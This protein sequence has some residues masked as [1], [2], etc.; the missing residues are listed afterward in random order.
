[1]RSN[2]CHRGPPFKLLYYD[3]I[4]GHGGMYLY[5]LA[6]IR[7][8]LRRGMDVTWVTCD[9]T[10]RHHELDLWTPFTGIYG[11]APAWR[12][13]IRYALGLCRLLAR[14]RRESKT[15]RVIV[16]QQFA[17]VPALELAF[18]AAAR[19]LGARCVLAPHDI[20]PFEGGE[21]TAWLLPKL[22][23]QYAAL[24]SHSAAGQAELKRLLPGRGTPIY[25]IPH[26][27]YNDSHARGARTP[28]AL[29]R[30][31]LGIPASC[32]VVLFLGQIRRE[33]GLEH[34]LRAMPRVLQEVPDAVLIVAGRPTHDSTSTYETLIKELGLSD[35]QV[36]LRW[37]YVADDDLPLYYR[38]ANVVAVP[39]TR[40]YQSGVCLTAYAF[41]RAV[42]AS[43]IAGLSEQVRDGLTGRLV[44]PADPSALAEALVDV[45]RNPDVADSMGEVG[46]AWAAEAYSWD[47]IAEQVLEMCRE[48]L[49]GTE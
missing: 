2:A 45:L 32:K 10:P 23:A 48:V 46:H 5:D 22:Y 1:M 26:G 12:R 43:A 38:S 13:G 27:H 6:F 47:N 30:Q 49:G 29:A 21:R 41:R 18:A 9:E 37:S 40:V 17:I 7:S 16:L 19:G 11:S 24:V 14:I 36:R 28:R 33:K 31:G 4:G 20:T 15:R 35:D 8:V 34:L 39:Y 44:R 42:V 25:L 3:P